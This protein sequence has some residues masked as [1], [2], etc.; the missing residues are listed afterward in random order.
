MKKQTQKLLATIFLIGALGFFSQG[1]AAQPPE[2]PGGGGPPSTIPINGLIGIALAA[3]A[4][5]GAKK[6]KEHK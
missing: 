6:L 3:G 5:F 1:L 4:Y 2:P